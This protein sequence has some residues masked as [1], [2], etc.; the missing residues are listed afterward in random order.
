MCLNVLIHSNLFH[1]F[2]FFFFFSLRTL[3]QTKNWND[4]DYPFLFFVLASL[5]RSRQSDVTEQNFNQSIAQDNSSLFYLDLVYCP[6]LT[7]SPEQ[8]AM[9]SV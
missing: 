1:F 7:M 4:L 6:S 2:V 8:A 5:T 3:M 9:L